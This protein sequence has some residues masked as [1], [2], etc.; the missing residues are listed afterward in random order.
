MNYKKKTTKTQNVLP[1]SP[2][3]H[4]DKAKGPEKHAHGHNFTTQNKLLVGCTF[5]GSDECAPCV[6][7]FA[8]YLQ[9]SC[10]S[11][12]SKT[13]IVLIFHINT[14]F[15]QKFRHHDTS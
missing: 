13:I 9:S 11:L 8:F 5:W 7:C 6:P 2:T 4:S 10:S 15:V 3:D 14:F 1:Y 12:G